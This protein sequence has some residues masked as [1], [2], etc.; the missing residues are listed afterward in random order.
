MPDM[1]KEPHWYEMTQLLVCSR[2]A[3]EEAKHPQRLSQLSMALAVGSRVA[4]R[5][6]CLTLNGAC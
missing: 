4:R 1:A 3:P 6:V 5:L 2:G